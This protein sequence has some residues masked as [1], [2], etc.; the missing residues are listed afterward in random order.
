MLPVVRILIGGDIS[1]KWSGVEH[2]PVAGGHVAVTRCNGV[3]E[4]VLATCR[5]L[6]PCVLVV[7]DAFI[8][9][10]KV[11]EF[12]E[13]I[14]FGRS[15]RVLVETEDHN[16]GNTERLIRMGCAGVI[17][18]D[19]TPATACHALQAILA[20]ELW[21][22]R[23]TLSRIVENLL[24]GIK[25]RLTFR[26]TEILGLA[27]EGLK[28]SQIAERLF[29]SPETVRWHLRAIYTKLGTHDRFY[30]ASHASV[31]WEQESPRRNR[32]QPADNSGSRK[33]RGTSPVMQEALLQTRSGEPREIGRIEGA[34]TPLAP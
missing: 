34:I 17:D 25:R 32:R 14:D 23:K 7:D 5:Y 16:R 12:Y 9:K 2:H 18:R 10:V 1:L 26:E 11:E 4:E 19:A 30:A 24:I 22:D 6:A 13:A 27:G 3:P 21:V 31:R 15:I 29:I 28:N 8:D 33:N 20:G